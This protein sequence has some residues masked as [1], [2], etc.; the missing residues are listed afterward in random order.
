MSRTGRRA[1]LPIA[2]Y[3]R[4]SSTDE[5]GLIVHSVGE[6]GEDLGTWDFTDA[7]GPEDFKRELVGAFARYGRVNWNS[8]ASYRTRYKQLWQFLTWAAELDPPIT[9]AAQI[10][11]FHWKTWTA[12][13]HSRWSLGSA[14]L[15]VGSLPAATRTLM[16]SVLRNKP[17]SSATKT[18]FTRA[19]LKAI[20]DAAARTVRSARLR[21]AEGAE[22]LEQWRAGQV[23]AGS[24]EDEWGKVLD[25][26]D[27]TDRF[28]RLPSGV[29]APRHRK[30]FGKGGARIGVKRLY[31][32][33]A[34]TGAAAVLLVC[35]EAWNESVLRTMTVPQ[36]WPNADGD[37][38][39]PAIYRMETDK[40]RRRR[41]RH[42]SNNLVDSGQGSTGWAMRQVIE[43]TQPARDSLARQGRP[44]DALLV[45]RRL[46]HWGLRTFEDIADRGALLRAVQAWREDMAKVGVE[47]PE[48]QLRHLRHSAQVHHGGPR[49]NTR[50][51]HEADYLMRDET[52]REDS[53]EAVEAGLSQAVSQAYEQVQMRMAGSLTGDAEHD[54][55]QLAKEADLD[56]DTARQ[57]VTGHLKTP[58]AS[59]TDYEHSPFTTA[60]PCA[61]SFLLCFACPNSIATSADLPRILYLHQA[62]NGLRSAVAPP[63]WAAD[64]AGHHARITD[65]LTTH[66]TEENW[67]SVLATLTDEDKNL[68]DQTLDRRL[69][70]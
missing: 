57:V 69:D 26:L 54:A 63:V 17:R 25:L 37:Q 28:P 38:D 59:C 10:T 43:M 9:Q 60:G 65:F 61:A 7:P 15:E 52:V 58:A 64:W 11:P 41:R 19:E 8:W 46:G 16:G 4:P 53:R 13:K 31:P 29:L 62:I 47:L 1:A 5:T 67:P 56:A 22:L 40:P 44:T 55:E 24:T 30:L 23:P 14:L 48:I 51:T 70:A 33:F 34:E 35:H 68:I 21:V 32:S 27:R 50:A 18:A 49:N 45:A 2:G 6:N 42:N 66:T 36:Q 20:R 12:D 39:A 3:R